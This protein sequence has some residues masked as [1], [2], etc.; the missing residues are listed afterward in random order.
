MI[1]PKINESAIIQIAIDYDM[2]V[3]E[4]RDICIKF[5]NYLKY[6][7]LEEFIEHRRKQQERGNGEFI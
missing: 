7:K 1:E 2:S 6:E 4:V 5:P 3:E